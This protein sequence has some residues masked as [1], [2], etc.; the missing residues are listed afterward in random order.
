[1]ARALFTKGAV[2]GE[3]GRSEEEGA[4]YAAVVRRFGEASEPA[5]R[6]WVARAVAGCKDL[7]R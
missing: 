5:L 7:I 6:E 1:V 4:G 2:R 3:L